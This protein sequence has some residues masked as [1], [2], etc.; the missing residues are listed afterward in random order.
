MSPLF[1]LLT[2]GKVKVGSTKAFIGLSSVETLITSKDNPL[3]YDENGELPPYEEESYIP[4]GIICMWSGA[5][6][7]VPSGWALCNGQNGTPNLM[8]KFVV[9]AGNTYSVG[10]TGG[11]ATHM[12]TVNEMPSHS[13]NV[14]DTNSAAAQQTCISSRLYG[15]SYNTTA[16]LIQPTGGSQPY[17]NMPP[18]YA[19]CFIMKL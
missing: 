1:F 2:Q 17:N 11:E 7:A 8:D 6:N 16:T 18:Y 14:L 19:L 3:I 4:S 5:S 9:G 13:H 15:A 12:L 10:A